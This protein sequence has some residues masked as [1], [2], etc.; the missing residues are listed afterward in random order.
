MM[1]DLDLLHD[2]MNDEWEIYW[3]WMIKIHCVMDEEMDD[4]YLLCDQDL[5]NDQDELCD[6]W[7]I[8]ND[9]IYCDMNENDEWLCDESHLDLLYNLLCDEW[10][11]IDRWISWLLC[12]ARFIVQ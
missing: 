7:W 8:I 12:D 9:N 10:S 4:Q 11:M 6:E 5:L 3:R 1:N 2:K